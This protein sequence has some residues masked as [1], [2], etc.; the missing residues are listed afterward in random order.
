MVLT[1]DAGTFIQH[2]YSVK[3]KLLSKRTINFWTLE[4]IQLRIYVIC[5]YV[6]MYIVCSYACEYSGG[7]QW[8]FL[9][10]F[11][12]ATHTCICIHTYVCAYVCL[13]SM[14]VKLLVC[15][16]KSIQ[17]TQICV[18]AGGLIHSSSLFSHIIKKI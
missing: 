6:C 16:N 2:S 18:I 15:S 3:D 5:M 11:S 1:N 7:Q 12:M 9:T 10:E 8:Y 17:V 14:L 4:R 13:F